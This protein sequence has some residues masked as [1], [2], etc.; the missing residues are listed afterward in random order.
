MPAPPP[1]SQLSREVLVDN[2]W[3][4]YCLDRYARRDGSEGLYYYI[5]MAGS[6]GIIPRFA[7]GST[8]LLQVRRYLL[9][10]TL[11]EFPIGGMHPGDEPLAVA[12]NE[13][14]EETGLAAGRW[15]DLG[16]FAPYKGV[17]N[18]RCYFFLAEDLTWGEQ[19]L[20]L[21]EDITVHQMPFDEARRTLLDQ[22]LG[23]GQSMSGLMLYD[24]WLAARDLA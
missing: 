17:S 4:R 23:C 10:T 15:Q 13:L 3:H 9:G 8:V 24:R 5:D 21:S 7:D 11:W 2:P 6:C 14:R 20:E 22:E 16:V 18:E 12:K 1:F 19:E